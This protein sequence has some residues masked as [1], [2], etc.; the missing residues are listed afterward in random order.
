MADLT[1][2]AEARIRAAIHA[3]EDAGLGEGDWESALRRLA[4]ATGSRSGQ[5][6]GL[7]SDWA[8]PFNLIT[9]TPPEALELYAEIGGHDPRVNSRVRVGAAAPEMSIRDERDFTTA[10]DARRHPAYGEAIDRFDIAHVCLSPI[11]RRG[12]VLIGLSVH[13]GRRQGDI[14]ESQREA[15]AAIAAHAR[16]AVR[17]QVALQGQATA[18]A[19][20][21]LASMD[22]AAFV[23]DRSGRVRDMTPRAEAL[24]REGDPL[25]VRGGRLVAAEAAEAAALQRALARATSAVLGPPPDE[26]MLSGTAGDTPLV[27]QVVPLTWTRSPFGVELAIVTAR[28]PGATR[29]SAAAAAELARGRYGLTA[30]ETRVVAGLLEGA[31]PQAIALGLGVSVDTV[32]THVRNVLRKAR[33]R[34]HRAHG[35]SAERLTGAPP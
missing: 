9:E 35:P 4:D 1:P 10:E 16:A 33:A 15:F 3:F 8:T 26:L 13:R 5:L 32:R 7:G 27:V 25:A 19:A 34:R 28:G 21:A 18:I 12:P 14:T 11:L 23:C 20:G 2:N 6:I 24:A 29:A 17:C 22:L 31:R 30:T